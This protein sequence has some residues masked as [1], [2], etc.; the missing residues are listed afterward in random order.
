MLIKCFIFR[1][2]KVCNGTS[3]R[4]LRD[5]SA[6]MLTTNCLIPSMSDQLVNYVVEN[7]DHIL[8]DTAVK[9]LYMCYS[10]GYTP[11]Q[12]DSFFSIASSIILR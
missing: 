7:G 3:S 1:H 10:L 6:N 11:A 8:G 12:A 9:L 2:E 4:L 5:I